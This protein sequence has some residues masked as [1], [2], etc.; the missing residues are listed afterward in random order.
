MVKAIEETFSIESGSVV[1]SSDNDW[2]LE[3]VTSQ[4][5]MPNIGRNNDLILASH[6]K[7]REAKL[8]F[9]PVRVKGHLDTSGFHPTHTHT[10][11]IP[12]H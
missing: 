4:S 3:L 10:A 9:K 2:E 6:Q 11:R 7:R 1:I 8:T 12:E 5:A